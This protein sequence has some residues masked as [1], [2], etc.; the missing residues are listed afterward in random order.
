MVDIDFEKF[1]LI[2]VTSLSQMFANDREIMGSTDEVASH[3]VCNIIFDKIDRFL[4]STHC[5][6]FEAFHK[7]RQF[8][9]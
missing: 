7:M 8:Q 5:H 2:N 4:I 9:N 6:D 3:A 1:D